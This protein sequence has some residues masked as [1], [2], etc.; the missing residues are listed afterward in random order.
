MNPGAHLTDPPPY[1]KTAA[2]GHLA[3]LL[4]STFILL[5]QVHR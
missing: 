5:G 4:T 1:P 2:S 3:E